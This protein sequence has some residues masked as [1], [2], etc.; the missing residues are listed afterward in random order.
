MLPDNLTAFWYSIHHSSRLDNHP[1]PF[2]LFQT[3]NLYSPLVLT[4]SW[5]PSFLFL[6]RKKWQSEKNSTFHYH[7]F[8]Q[9][10]AHKLCF[11]PATMGE[12]FNLPGLPLVAAHPW[13]LSAQRHSFSNDLCLTQIIYET[14]FF[15][16]FPSAFKYVEISPIFKKIICSSYF[17]LVVT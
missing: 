15:K 9:Y 17:P 4:L 10:S 6:L 2:P 14:S 8:P 16:P 12:L 5:L 1:L 7:L 11:P 3:S 13:V